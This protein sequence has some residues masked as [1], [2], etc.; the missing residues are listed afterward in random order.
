MRHH[1]RFFGSTRIPKKDCDE[2]H[3]IEDYEQLEGHIV[4]VR[5]GNVSKLYYL[6]L[7][8]DNNNYLITFRL[9][10]CLFGT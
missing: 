8:L 5:R 6:C 7:F 9:S 1:H 2:Y 10:S 3:V 4:V